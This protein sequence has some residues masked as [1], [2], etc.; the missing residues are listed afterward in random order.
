MDMYYRSVGRNCN[1]LLNTTP[2][3]TGL[4]PEVI[5]PHYANFGKEIRRRFD[6]P[7]AET[8]GEGDKVELVLKKPAKIDNKKTA[9]ALV[10]TTTTRTAKERER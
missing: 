3:T 7:V 4:I 1:L 8:K 9:S 5:V 10:N 6:K 2:D